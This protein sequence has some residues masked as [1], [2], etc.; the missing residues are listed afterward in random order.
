MKLVSSKTGLVFRLGVLATAVLMSQ[1]AL[2]VGTRAG[3]DI[4]NTAL[5]DYEVN[6]VAQDQ[7]SADADFVVDRR[8]D[9][10]LSV[11]DVNLAPV[12]PGGPPAGDPDYYVEFT[13]TN[14]SNGVLD[15]NVA[16]AQ[17]A[18]GNTF[19][20]NGDTDT[21]DFT[22]VDYAVSADT[23]GGTNPDPVR[24]GLQY[25]DELDA[26]EQI[27][28]WVF[29]DPQ[30]GLANGAIAGVALTLNGAEPGTPG[31]E[32]A[33]LVDGTDDAL[34]I[35][36]VFADTADGSP[37]SETAE[38]GFVV[39]TADLAV[40][41]AFNVIAGDLGSGL[42]IPGATVEY[43]I[44]IVNSSTTTAADPISITDAIDGDL[45]FIFDAYDTG[46][47]ASEDIELDNGG[48]VTLCT[49]DANDADTDGCELTAGSI[50]VGGDDSVS[51]AA[52]TTLTVSFQVLI[53]DPATTP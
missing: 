12:V 9:F 28:I 10:T 52:N 46:A 4:T 38:D 53:P 44:T 47:A 36:N 1:Q 3:T 34:Q 45:Q 51:L 2:A 15:F 11:T 16:L 13:L 23:V 6:G 22:T 25:V 40:T 27:R 43:T 30:L 50:I 8:V 14:T 37:N 42:P 39:V 48:T 41:K 17:I 29:A 26:D 21:V 24:G 49:A 31:T 20:G 5:V 33:A 18:S 7:L 35:D 32:G 19:G